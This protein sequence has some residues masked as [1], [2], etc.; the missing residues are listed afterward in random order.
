MNRTRWGLVWLAL[1]TAV[2]ALE[3]W[4]VGNAA[5]GDTLSESVIPLVLSHPA[6]WWA[7]LVAW[8]AF[9]GWLTWHFWWQYRRRDR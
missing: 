8:L 7:T 4:A 6:V 3:L 9:A 5:E 2:L 1:L